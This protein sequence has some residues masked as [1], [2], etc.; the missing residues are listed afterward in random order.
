MYKILQLQYLHFRDSW[1]HDD[2]KNNRKSK[3]LI[4]SRSAS[5]VRTY[6]SLSCSEQSLL[7]TKGKSRTHS[8]YEYLLKDFIRTGSGPD[9]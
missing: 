5:R 9:T 7:G 1:R 3:S 6:L 8:L 2:R 4:S